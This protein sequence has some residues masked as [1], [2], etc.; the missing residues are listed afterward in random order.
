MNALVALEVRLVSEGSAA[1]FARE[2]VRLLTV[3][4]VLLLVDYACAK[5]L[6]SQ[7]VFFSRNAANNTAQSD[8]GRG[9]PHPVRTWT[10]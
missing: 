4:T 10:R 6:G 7:S 9:R 2:R 8:L 1:V 3:D 5:Q